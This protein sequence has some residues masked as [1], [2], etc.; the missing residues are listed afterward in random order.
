MDLFR[1]CSLHD[2]TEHDDHR[3]LCPIRNDT[4]STRPH[5]LLKQSGSTST[6]DSCVG[7]IQTANGEMDVENNG[8]DDFVHGVPFL[9]STYAVMA[10]EVLDS[11]GNFNT[12]GA[13]ADIEVVPGVSGVD[14]FGAFQTPRAFNHPLSSGN[15]S[16]NRSGTES[17][18]DEGKKLSV[19]LDVLI[20]LISFFLRFSWRCSR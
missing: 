20:M 14:K 11:S 5:H 8:L 19:G 7:L 15:N 3:P 17:N 2:S 18:G 16:S 12:S 4:L 10:Y 13:G 6:A 9:R 1:L